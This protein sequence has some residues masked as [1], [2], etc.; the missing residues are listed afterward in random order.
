[1]ATVFQP[2]DKGADIAFGNRFQRSLQAF[3]A[4]ELFEKPDGLLVA[5][6]GCDRYS[7]LGGEPL[8]KP[9]ADIDPLDGVFPEPDEGF[10]KKGGKPLTAQISPT[11]LILSLLQSLT[12]YLGLI[13][14][15]FAG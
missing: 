6:S 5:F 11:Q 12:D 4:Q 15:M 2:G 7:G 10:I 13:F 1:V 9:S 14:G 8:V 3:G